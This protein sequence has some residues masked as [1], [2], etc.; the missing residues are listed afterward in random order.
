MILKI[1][2]FVTIYMVLV[3]FILLFFKGAT[4]TSNRFDEKRE[5]EEFL[6]KI[7]KKKL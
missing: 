2:M 4:L 3:L 6:K 1:I 7:R 5:A